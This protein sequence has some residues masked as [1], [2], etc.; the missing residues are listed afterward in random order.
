MVKYINL[1]VDFRANVDLIRKGI[2]C[3]PSYVD[4]IF[5][6]S[7]LSSVYLWSSSNALYSNCLVYVEPAPIPSLHIVIWSLEQFFRFVIKDNFFKGAI[8]ITLHFVFSAAEHL[9]EHCVLSHQVSNAPHH[10]L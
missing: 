7:V 8:F 4:T 2:F 1:L 10:L 9:S 5:A 6:P 3:L